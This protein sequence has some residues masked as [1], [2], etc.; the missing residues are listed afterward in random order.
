MNLLEL[1][2]GKKLCYAEYGNPAGTPVFSFH[3]NPGSRL[4]WGAMPGSPFLPNVLLIAPDRPG[5]GRTDF[6]KRAL[7]HWPQDVAELANHLGI[8]TFYLFAPSGGAPYALACAWKIP[9]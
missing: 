6:K 4:A 7:E 1:S 9:L 5:Y 8:K 3:G 2:D